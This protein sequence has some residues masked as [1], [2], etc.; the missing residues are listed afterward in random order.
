MF[1]YINNKR[2]L[3]IME[4]QENPLN[5]RIKR[6]IYRSCNRGC[7]E[8][9]L[10]LGRFA[11]TKLAQLNHV[12]IDEYERLIEESDADIF[13]WLT[14]KIPLPERYKGGVIEKIHTIPHQK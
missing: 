7:K 8:T 2:P 10:L 4:K 14:G 12:E 6:L 3:H 9:D 5:S 1:P 11:V 13:A